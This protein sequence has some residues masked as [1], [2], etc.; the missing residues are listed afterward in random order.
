[1]AQGKAFLGDAGGPAHQGYPVILGPGLLHHE[2]GLLQ[3]LLR[4]LLLRLNYARGDERPLVVERRKQ[5]GAA[6]A[7]GPGRYVGD[8]DVES[9]RLGLGVGQGSLGQGD[10]GQDSQPPEILPGGG[11]GYR[12]YVQGKNVPGPSFAAAMVRMPEPTPRSN[13]D[14]PGST[15]CSRASRQVYVVGW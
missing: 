15:N 14:I 11:D 8:Q 13:T 10:P 5:M 3:R 2:A 6:F 4:F 12:V 7:D 1:M 9:A